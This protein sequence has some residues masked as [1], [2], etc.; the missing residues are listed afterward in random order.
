MKKIIRQLFASILIVGA[1]VFTNGPVTLAAPVDV[2]SQDACNG[3]TT[4][5]PDKN[6][7]GLFGIIQIVINVMLIL[8]GAIAVI[9]II[10]GG[11]SYMFSQGDQSK[12]KQAK[13]TILYSVIGLVVALSA[14]AIVNFVVGKL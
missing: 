7:S 14:F 11:M 8:A 6:G 9:M 10:I 5:C 3:D 4:I 1:F 12:V 13:D 2:F